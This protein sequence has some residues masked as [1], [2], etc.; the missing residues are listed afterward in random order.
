MQNFAEYYAWAVK[1][2]KAS[3]IFLGHGTEDI[4]DE[5]WWLLTG[6]LN[7]PIDMPEDQAMAT[8]I[9][10][11]AGA[12]IRDLID[13]RI[14][15]RIP[16]AY[17]LHEAYQNGYKFYV[18]ERVLIPRSPIAELIE[19][20]FVPFISPQS[21]K[22]VLDLCTGS[23]CLAILA[24]Y[25]F[26]DAKIDASDLS[27][28]ALVVAAQNTKQHGFEARIRLHHADVFSTL[29]AQKY[30]LILSNPPYVDAEDFESM[31]LEYHHEPGMALSAGQDGLD[32][33]HRILS[34]AKAHLNPG[35]ILVVEVGNSMEAVMEAYPHLPFYWLE[36][37]RGGQGV[38]LL[39]EEEL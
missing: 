8:Q 23:A 17:L 36:F 14:L 5:A 13:K 26:P 27:Q 29:T 22:Q 28:E 4:R 16:T 24:A 19:N 30:D 34:E 33:V 2:F 12:R 31:P 9:S 11:E 20:Q 21:V 25:A 15:A 7:L 39:R 1:R 3:P 18:D 35:G 6:A 32:I 37:E 38:F 10:R